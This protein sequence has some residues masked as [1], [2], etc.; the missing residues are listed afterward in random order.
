ML[1]DIL[2]IVITM[3]LGSSFTR[4]INTLAQCIVRLNKANNMNCIQ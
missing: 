3:D 4:I 1:L 2:S